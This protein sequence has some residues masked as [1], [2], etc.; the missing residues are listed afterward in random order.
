MFPPSTTAALAFNLICAGNTI[1]EKPVEFSLV[2]RVDLKAERY[3][4]DDCN[5]TLPIAK[6]TETEIVFEDDLPGPN[7][8]QSRVS[9]ENGSY[10]SR[11]RID[12]WLDE[13]ETGRCIAAPFSGFPVRKF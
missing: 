13:T 12:I 5:H 11:A 1:G 6:V 9:R 2:I 3:C 7:G 10:Y 8:I 4:M